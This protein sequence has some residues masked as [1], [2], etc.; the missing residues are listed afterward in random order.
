MY[1]QILQIQLFTKYMENEVCR[2]IDTEPLMAIANNIL[3]NDVDA[4]FGDSI[5]KFLFT[6][7]EDEQLKTTINDD[8]MKCLDLLSN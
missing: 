5:T 4:Q 7:N 2:N 3:Q 8:M 1:L 6:L